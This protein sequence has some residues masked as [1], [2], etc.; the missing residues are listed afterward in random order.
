MIQLKID[1]NL[2]SDAASLLRQRGHDVL[3][4]HEQG[5][6]GH[7][8]VDIANVCRQ[9]E[10]TIITLDLDFSDIRE[11]PPGDYHGIIVLRLKNQS[12]ASVLNVLGRIIPMFDSESPVGRLWVVDE[13]QVRIRGGSS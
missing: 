6:K 5:L 2:H 12:R 10:R 1:E 4:V 8:D 9:E 11:Y 13:H 3:T 7:A